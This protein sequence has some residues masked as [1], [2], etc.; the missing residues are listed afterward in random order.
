MLS[1]INFYPIALLTI[2]GGALYFLVGDLYNPDS[3]D[4]AQYQKVCEE[5]VADRDNKIP[6]DAKQSL[7]Y[8]VDYLLPS[9]VGEITNPVEK[10]VKSCAQKLSQQL[11]AD[12]PPVVK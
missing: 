7:I 6:R 11:M 12:T 2:I 9:D 3:I 8:K 5:Y 4:Y 10:A 1:N